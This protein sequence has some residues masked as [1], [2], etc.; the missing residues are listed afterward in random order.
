MS[1]AA[2]RA[3]EEAARASPDDL[4][5]GR[6]LA[7]AWRRAGR[8][9]EALSELCRLVAA[10]D[11]E[12]LEEV[13]RAT[14]PE[15]QPGL[16]RAPGS[17][18]RAR[19]EL[20]PAGAVV[21][22]GDRAVIPLAQ[23]LLALGPDLA[24]RWR[25]P[26]DASGPPPQACGI[27]VLHAD[28]A[29][30]VLR[31]G[32]DG[33]PLARAELASPP[34]SLSSWGDLVLV[35]ALDVDAAEPYLEWDRISAF[36]TGPAGLT[37]L[38]SRTGQRPS[39]AAPRH[40]AFGFPHTAFTDLPGGFELVA[41]VDGRALRRVPID[42]MRLRLLD[43]DRRGLLVGRTLG[44]RET[45]L[46]EVDLD[47][48]EPRWTCAVPG[49]RLELI[50]RTTARVLAQVSRF[51]DGGLVAIE[52]SAGAIVWRHTWRHADSVQALA[53]AD[54]TVGLVSGDGRAL[55]VQALDGETG[56]PLWEQEVLRPQLELRRAQLLPWLD[57]WLLLAAGEDAVELAHLLPERRR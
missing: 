37:P 13:E 36:R 22:V 8:P 39:L 40:A 56:A 54:E 53:L 43:L 10:G 35:A 49:D 27:D 52:R 45:S 18:V 2:L 7:R 12:A 34:V 11:E 1:D 55:R 47:S 32:D 42:D 15:R 38:W 19:H 24:V 21:T 16:V 30:L 57:G 5:A 29:A 26:V 25:A 3:L 33:R 31:A 9:R 6:A 48:G 51:G 46:Q 23:E 4:Q 41:A 14:R 28:G 50:G 17:I 20:S 44:S